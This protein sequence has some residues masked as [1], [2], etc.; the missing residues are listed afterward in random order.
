MIS[1]RRQNAFVEDDDGDDDAI[2]ADADATKGSGKAGTRV[3]RAGKMRP[4]W[5]PFPGMKY[6]IGC[7]KYLPVD[8]FPKGSSQC[9]I[10][11]PVF[12]HMRVAAARQG[13]SAELKEILYDPISRPK[14]LHGY[15][16]R[17]PEPRAGKRRNTIDMAALLSVFEEEFALFHDS[18]EG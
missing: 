14:L 1:I 11:K 3:A 6:C 16:M 2:V 5:K 7:E 10:D 18:Y 17:C 15:R 9:L 13:C 12:Q 8:K 4:S